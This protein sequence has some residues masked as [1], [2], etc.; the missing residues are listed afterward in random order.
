[1][2]VTSSNNGGPPGVDDGPNNRY[3]VCCASSSGEPVRSCS[4]ER[5]PDCGPDL[6]GG[7]PTNAS[8]SIVRTMPAYPYPMVLKFTGKGDVNDSSNYVPMP[9]TTRSQ[10]KFR[11]LGQGLFISSPMSQ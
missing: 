9:S 3:T 1:M 7:N 6:T 2:K 4:Y 11:W 5:K 10:D 8:G